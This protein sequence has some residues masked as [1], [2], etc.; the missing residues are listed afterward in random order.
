VERRVGV[1]LC[2]CHGI[3][4]KDFTAEHGVSVS[5]PGGKSDAGCKLGLASCVAVG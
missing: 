5:K 4:W 2:L 1:D 3:V